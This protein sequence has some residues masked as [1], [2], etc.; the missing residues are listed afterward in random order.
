M[1]QTSPTGPLVLT[2]S[3][4]AYLA[5]LC[6]VLSL[7][8][9]MAVVGASAI[10]LAILLG[11]RDLRLV[12][13]IIFGLLVAMSL[14]ALVDE[15]GALMDGAVNMTRLTA[16]ILTVMLLSSLLG[17]SSD[18][19]RISA[20]LF[21]GR[22]TMR[23]LSVTFGTLVLAVPLNFG[24]VG[25]VSSMIAG[26]VRRQ[27]DSAM[28]RNAS[29]G[30]LRGFGASPTCSP[31]SISVVMTVTFLPGL[32]S[33]QLIAF[34]LPL[35]TAYLL[36]GLVFTEREAEAPPRNPVVATGLQRYLPWLRFMAIIGAICLGAFLL[37]GPGGLSYSKAVTLSCLGAV[38]VLLVHGLVTSPRG[39][40]NPLPSMAPVSNE[41]VI[42]GGSAFLGALIS[43]FALK[44]LGAGFTLPGWG[45]PLV[46][47]LVPWLFFAGGMVGLNPIVI[48]TLTGGVLGPIWP[49]EAVLGLGVGMVS[50]WGITT[51]GTPYSANSL[52]MER[53]TGYSAKVASYRWN[54]AHSVASLLAGGIMAA[55]LTGYLAG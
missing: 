52:L 6:G 2:R 45:Y 25:V 26:Q 1:T 12:A 9:G 30:T 51:G 46:A 15:P 49:V 19:E 17:R 13:R 22:P 43:S 38:G 42:V 34:S 54:L 55:A 23:Y 24:S 27:G 39:Q 14:L 32:Q 40:G 21:A 10:V 37:S 50:G 41:L 36:S 44:W 3:A 16:L 4:L 11:W 7:I 5:L 31:L 47:A 8:P 29:R 18:L 33:W 28:A 53:V 20:S 35:A 48:G